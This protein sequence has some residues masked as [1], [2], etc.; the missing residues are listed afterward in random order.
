MLKKALQLHGLFI[1]KNEVKKVCKKSVK[2][3]GKGG[4]FD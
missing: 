3:I 4:Y 1:G 2:V